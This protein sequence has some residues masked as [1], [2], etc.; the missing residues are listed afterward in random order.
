MNNGKPVSIDRTKFLIT[1]S[2]RSLL[3]FWENEMFNDFNTGW[4][5]KQQISI[6]A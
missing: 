2:P 5:V 6:P 4:L 3:D 1:D